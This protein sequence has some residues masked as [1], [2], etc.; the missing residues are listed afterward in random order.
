MFIEYPF[1]KINNS[2]YCQMHLKYIADK[3][4]DRRWSWDKK[5]VE[6]NLPLYPPLIMT[7]MIWME[8]ARELDPFDSEYFYWVDAGFVHFAKP[9]MFYKQNGDL[10]FQLWQQPWSFRKVLW[11]VDMFASDFDIKMMNVTVNR[12]ESWS[13]A[14]A[15]GGRRGAVTTVSFMQE[16]LTR[17]VMEIRHLEDYITEEV[18]NTI[19]INR[20]PLMFSTSFIK[21]MPY[22]LQLSLNPRVPHQP[23]F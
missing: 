10:P 18:V 9:F 6:F 11:H 3:K 1:S 8:L 17:V 15:Y 12:G 5:R 7:K 19:A 2:W 16:V 22:M 20:Y 21:N 13:M 23:L 14:G 4:A